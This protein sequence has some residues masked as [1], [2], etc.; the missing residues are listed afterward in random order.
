[1]RKHFFRSFIADPVC[2][3]S[4]AG[5]HVDIGRYFM[6]VEK[7]AVTIPVNAHVCGGLVHFDTNEFLWHHRPEDIAHA[8]KTTDG[9]AEWAPDW[10]V[11]LVPGAALADERTVFTLAHPD[12][13]TECGAEVSP[14][15]PCSRRRC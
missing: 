7:S 14:A 1:M 6:A 3:S 8:L 9:R 15:R 2:A 13:C 4:D 11:L 10:Q 12:E 5:H